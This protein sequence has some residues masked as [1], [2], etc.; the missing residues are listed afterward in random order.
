MVFDGASGAEHS[1]IPSASGE[2]VREKTSKDC[3]FD[4]WKHLKLVMSGQ[5]LCAFFVG[6]SLKGRPKVYNHTSQE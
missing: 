1:Q 5:F 4:R 6:E 3:V 2:F